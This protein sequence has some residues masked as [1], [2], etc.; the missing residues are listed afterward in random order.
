MDISLLPNTFIDQLTVQY[1]GAASLYGAGAIGG[2]IHLSNAPKYGQGLKFQ[3]AQHYGSFNRYLQSYKAG[4]SNKNFSS[5]IKVF[6]STADN[7]FRYINT[8]VAGS[9]TER[10]QH[11]GVE[12]QGL[13]VQNYWKWNERNQLSY[14]FWIQQNDIEVPDPITVSSG[15]LDTQTDNFYR[16]LLTW[17][18]QGE[19]YTS[20]LKTALINHKTAFTGFSPTTY[21][22]LVNEYNLNLRPSESLTMILGI[23]NT[24]EWIN[25]DNHGVNSPDRN[26]T[27]LFISARKQLGTATILNIRAREELVAG[28]LTPFIPSIGIEHYLTREILLKSS[29]SRNYLLPTFN[30]LYWSSA[31]GY[32]NP[33]IRP[34]LSWSEELG[35]IYTPTISN[36]FQLEMEVTGFSNQVE[37][38]ILWAPVTSSEWSPDNIKRVWSRGLESKI[39]A[40]R[41]WG[42]FKLSI[43]GNYNLTKATNQKVA[44]NGNISEVGKQLI[45]TPLHTG[46]LNLTFATGS[47]KWGWWHH[48]TGKQYT[49]GDN[50]DIQAV[51]KYG[52]S[53][54]VI[55]QTFLL[56]SIENSLQI[57][58]NNLFNENYLV[59]AGYPMPLR[60]IRIGLTIKL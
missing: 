54:L 19:N 26:R 25:S 28:E 50:I 31:G 29:V 15:S 47:I 43:Q 56:G 32:G 35:M 40:S 36:G 55:Q 18:H 16:S 59:R 33:S 20:S 14:L 48:I 39:D 46:K 10:R 57:E 23:N 58:V 6:R 3:L 27:S 30:Q 37:D 53:T 21:H 5:A 22:S 42:Q 49:T 60:N 8:A 51:T 52:V 11:S 41:S 45:Y 12:Q 44:D 9:P 24:Y 2:A 7:D 4:W 1:G 17:T 13:L 34:E 38:W